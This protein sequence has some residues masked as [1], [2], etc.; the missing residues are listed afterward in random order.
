MEE[1]ERIVRAYRAAS[2]E[3]SREALL[4]E[5]FKAYQTI[6]FEFGYD[7][8][9]PSGDPGKRPLVTVIPTT[10]SYTSLHPKSQLPAA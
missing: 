3:S 1:A 5:F 4:D 2:L 7:A 10:A 8:P 6:N 9:L